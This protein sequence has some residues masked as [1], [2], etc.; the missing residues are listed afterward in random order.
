ML[1]RMH[2]ERGQ[3]VESKISSGKPLYRLDPLGFAHGS[4]VILCCPFWKKFVFPLE[5]DIVV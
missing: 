3:K 1:Q 4:V 5:N 2:I